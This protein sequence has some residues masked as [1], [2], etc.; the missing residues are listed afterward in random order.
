MDEL[1]K[2]WVLLGSGVFLW[3]IPPAFKL[4]KIPAVMCFNGAIACLTVA[5]TT[6]KRLTKVE[7]LITRQMLIEEDLVDSELAWQ[8]DQREEELK[9]KYLLQPMPVEPEPEPEPV[10]VREQLQR[11]LE[12]T[13]RLVNEF[14]DR[15]KKLEKPKPLLSKGSQKLLEYGSKKDWL[16]LRTLAKNWGRNNEYNSKEVESFCQELVTAKLAEWNGDGKW[17]V[18]R[19]TS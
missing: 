6:S 16:E 12:A 18:C 11:N 1:V 10:D 14:L 19:E 3:L 15:Q 5:T 4:G 17:R 13:D 8:A 9:Q 2:V 7:S